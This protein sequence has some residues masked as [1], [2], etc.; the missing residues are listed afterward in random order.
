VNRRQFFVTLGRLAAGGALAALGAKV[1]RKAV[2]SAAGARCR[3]EG[4]CA[5][6]QISAT[7]GLPRA[8]SFRQKRGAS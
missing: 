5:P 1:A 3:N 7:C 4:W 6:C 2:D 8:L